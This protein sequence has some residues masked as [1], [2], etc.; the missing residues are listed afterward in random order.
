MNLKYLLKKIE[1][2]S[3]LP[4]EKA[5]EKIIRRSTLEAILNP[6]Q[7]AMEK[8]NYSIVETTPI[9]LKENIHYMCNECKFIGIQRYKSLIQYKPKCNCHIDNAKK[10]TNANDILDVKKYKTMFDK[11][12]LEI[13]PIYEKSKRIHSEFEYKCKKCQIVITM[14]LNDLTIHVKQYIGQNGCKNC[15]ELVLINPESYLSLE[16]ALSEIIKRESYDA[17]I[18]PI[19]EAMKKYNFSIIEKEP[20][21]KKAHVNH[22]CNNCLYKSNCSFFNLLKKGKCG[23]C[24]P[25]MNGN[26]NIIKK[27]I[28]TSFQDILNVPKYKDIFDKTSFIVMD[29][30]FEKECTLSSAFYYQCTECKYEIGPNL[31]SYM[32]TRL[33]SNLESKGCTQCRKNEHVY[34]QERCKPHGKIVAYCEEC[35]G[36]GLCKEHGKNKY[37]CSICRPSSRYCKHDIIKNSCR[38]C[39]SEYFCKHG[40][41]KY[42]CKDC[43]YQG[44]LVYII[45]SR[46]QAAIKKYNATKEKSSIKYLG[47]TVEHLMYVFKDYYNV[48]EMP[49]EYHIDH[50]KPISKFDLS[51]KEEMEKAFHWTNL[52]PLTAQHNLI[53]SN[54]WSKEL[55]KWWENEVQVKLELYPFNLK[56][57][58]IKYKEYILY[59]MAPDKFKNYSDFLSSNKNLVVTSTIDSLKTTK[60]FKFKCN[61]CNTEHVLVQESFAN[62]MFKFSAEDFCTTCYRE[63]CDKIKFEETKKEILEQTGHI[64]LTCNF[65]G[66][67]TCTYKCCNCNVINSSY[68]GNLRKS[69]GICPS[70]QNNLHKLDFNKLE[71][72]VSNLGF[73]LNMKP[74]EYTNNKS[75]IVVCKCGNDKYK[76]SLSDLKRGRMCVQC[77]GNRK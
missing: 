65:G 5:F 39:G 35:G 63:K 49:D 4:L 1:M 3:Y 27:H 66:D 45:R 8:F 42:R 54:R 20:I 51:I 47:C 61:I 69:I 24:N 75:I 55:N 16:E 28:V 50:I 60:K 9:A 6:I 72:E 41:F 14:T 21:Q 7:L 48:T 71:K 33:K 32:S 17:I 46:M 19:Q 30:N 22:M 12:Q 2:E 15:T 64:L 53:K 68:V 44:Y 67:R 11:I 59:T 57:E 23:K 77:V 62:K 43:N 36:N 40:I 76:V 37:A 34:V 74:D 38:E 13:V 10:V 58:S 26:D 29:K 18:P 56:N 25:C 52:Q 31:L 70:C 73:K